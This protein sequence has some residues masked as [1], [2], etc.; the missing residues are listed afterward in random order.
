[1]HIFI[2]WILLYIYREFL[3]LLLVWPPI[4]TI[5]SLANHHGRV[6]CCLG[7]QDRRPPA[8]DSVAVVV[9]RLQTKDIGS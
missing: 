3:V 2:P 5:I 1:M 4:I 8:A 9:V 6:L 7:R